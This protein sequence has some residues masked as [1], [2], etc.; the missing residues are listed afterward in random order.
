MRP[1]AAT[2][3]TRRRKAIEAL[4]ISLLV[5]SQAVFFYL[6]LLR[7]ALRKASPLRIE[8][9][10]REEPDNDALLGL[11]ERREEL[12]NSA[13]AV[14]TTVVIAGVLL[15]GL[16][17][18]DLPARLGA[19][20]T[21]G[22]SLLLLG[23]GALI[24]R[25]LGRA[26]AE[27]IVRS[28]TGVLSALDRLL[29]VRRIAV[30]IEEA[31]MR[32]AGARRQSAE[33]K[34]EEEILEVVT[35][36]E[37]EGGIEED[38][39]EMIENIIEFRDLDVSLLM[40]PRT[41]MVAIEDTHSLLDALDLILRSGHSRIPVYHDN[42]DHVVG[43]LYERDVLRALGRADTSRALTELMS[44]PYFVPESVRVRGLL[45]DLKRRGIHIAIV[46]DEYGGTA[47]LIT[48]ADV[49][50][51]IVGEFPEKPLRTEE[52]EFRALAP[53][54]A[55]VSGTM[56]IDELNER[57]DLS[58]PEDETFAT[59]GGLAASV[60]GRVPAPGERLRYRNIALTVVEADERN[61]RRLR[62]DV[63]NEPPDNT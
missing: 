8:K 2:S 15:L 36:G 59:I 11:L 55:E 61:V 14:R 51:E 47:G 21:F 25:A 52:P 30:W 34:V 54:A 53:E 45:R 58:L 13:D 63:V 17:L 38:A 50:E 35:E 10:S 3:A 24:G 9:E 56:R 16:L 46:L 29:A 42:R 20:A 32:L 62:V 44:P 28:N 27:G 57:M 6:T 23:T 5:L 40:T 18:E 37:R 33:E 4:T 48:L 1:A 49:V 31:L 26:Q 41:R 19:L 60:S 43:I 7:T 39:K 22:G 12:I